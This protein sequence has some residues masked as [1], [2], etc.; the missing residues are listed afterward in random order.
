LASGFTEFYN[1]ATDGGSMRLLVLLL[2]SFFSGSA[3]A[4]Q[5]HDLR[6]ETYFLSNEWTSKSAIAVRFTNITSRELALPTDNV[7]VADYPVP[8]SNF[9]GLYYPKSIFSCS[10][11]PGLISVSFE[12]KPQ[13]P[14]V[15]TQCGEAAA[16]AMKTQAPEVLKRAKSWTILRPGESATRQAMIGMVL[17][18]QA[19]MFT[20]IHAVY[21][22]PHFSQVEQEQLK[23]AGITVPAGNYV[24]DNNFSFGTDGERVILVTPDGSRRK[25]LP[26]SGTR[27]QI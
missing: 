16:V 23:D 26:N 18:L 21:R 14:E 2:A 3:C 9:R 17:P 11:I 13:N 1:A 22:S 7:Y 20:Q 8:G 6:I 5:G 27:P 12:F 4:Q 19:G 10:P 25:V 24:S 15:V